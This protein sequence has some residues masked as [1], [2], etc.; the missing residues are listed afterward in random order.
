MLSWLNVRSA[1]LDEMVS[2]DGPGNLHL[3]L[4]NLCLDRQSA[5]LYRCLECSYSSLYCGECTVK[6]HRVLPL[7]RLEVRSYSQ[8]AVTH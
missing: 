5:P 1:V 4:C 7:H 3:D 6:L 8:R 2:L